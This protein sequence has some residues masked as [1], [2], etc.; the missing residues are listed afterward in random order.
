MAAPRLLARRNLWPFTYER[1][2]GVIREALAGYDEK[3]T[4]HR[5]VMADALKRGDRPMVWSARVQL[6]RIENARRNGEERLRQL[7]AL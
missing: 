5:E 3:L 1:D 2:R 4:I 6:C 7:G